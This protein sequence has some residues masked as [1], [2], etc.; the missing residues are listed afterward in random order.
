LRTEL[1]QLVAFEQRE[2]VFDVSSERR[3]GGY[4]KLPVQL[5]QTDRDTLRPGDLL[6]ASAERHMSARDQCKAVRID[7]GWL[8]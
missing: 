3:S 8:H 7:F 5:I 6:L 4:S 2:G 1:A